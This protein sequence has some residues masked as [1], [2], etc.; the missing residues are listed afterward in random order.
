MSSPQPL[1]DQ[2][3]SFRAD[4]RDPRDGQG[5]LI[6]TPSKSISIELLRFIAVR[7]PVEQLNQSPGCAEEKLPR[8]PPSFPRHDRCLSNISNLPLPKS[9]AHPRH[10]YTP[11]WDEQPPPPVPPSLQLPQVLLCKPDTCHFFD[12]SGTHDFSGP[13]T[14]AAGYPTNTPSPIGPPK[15]I[16]HPHPSYF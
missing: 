9:A 12:G 1:D 3:Q 15:N 14:R 6:S 11:S 8:Q 16:T 5:I 2:S 13:T 4:F 10:F 7:Q